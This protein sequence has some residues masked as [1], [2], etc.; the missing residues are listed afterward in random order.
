MIVILILGNVSLIRLEISIFY[1]KEIVDCLFGKMDIIQERIFPVRLISKNILKMQ[2]LNLTSEYS[3]REI[4]N[5]AVDNLLS[6]L[7]YWLSLLRYPVITINSIGVI[8]NLCLFLVLNFLRKRQ[9]ISEAGVIVLLNQSIIDFQN[10]LLIIA[11]QFGNLDDLPETYG[12]YEW[13]RAVTCYFWH[14]QYPYWST[15]SVSVFNEMLLA[16]ER[17][18]AIVHPFHHQKFR[19]KLRF[20]IASNYIGNIIFNIPYMGYNEYGFIVHTCVVRAFVGIFVVERYYAVIW[21]IEA[22]VIPGLGLLYFN[23]NTIR[24]LRKT[25]KF[26]Q[27]DANLISRAA[28]LKSKASRLLVKASI[29]IA[30]SYYLTMTFITYFYTAQSLEGSYDTY[31][32]RNIVGTG[33]A[34]IHFSLNP[35]IVLFFLPGLRRLVVNIFSKGKFDV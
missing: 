20:I 11:Y 18:F 6:S 30:I 34:S 21:S 17:Y 19:K 24:T 8:S 7:T 31:D 14:T 2:L 29:C 4:K 27:S 25:D 9:I 5:V 13:I 28:E 23:I 35:I 22:Y 1:N 3:T 10:V 33:M 26:L 15:Y 12:D 16:L 32:I